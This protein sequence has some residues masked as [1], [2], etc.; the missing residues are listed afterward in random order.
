MTW[1]LINEF[2]LD[3]APAV[4]D[5][6]AESLAY[7]SLVERAADQTYLIVDELFFS[8]YASIT[9]ECRTIRVDR[10]GRLLYDS[11]HAG[12]HDGYGCQMDDGQMALLQRTRWRLL[13]LSASGAVSDVIDLT[14]VSKGMPRLV[15]WTWRKTFLIAFSRGVG[16]IEIAEIDRHGRLLW[17]LP[18]R[19]PVLGFAGSIQLL[20]NGHVLV[21]DEFH[22]VAAELDHDGSWVWQFGTRGHSA[23]AALCL[24]NPKAIRQADDGSRVIADTRNHRVIHL[25]VHGHIVH[26][27][28]ASGSWSSPSFASKAPDGHFLVCDAGN[29]RVV[30]LDPSGEV[31][32]QYGHPIAERRWLSFPRSVTI[33]DSGSYLVADTAN[34]RVV[35]VCNGAVRV[36]ALTDGTELFWP[37][38][39][40]KLS[41]GHYLIADGRN[42]RILEVSATGKVCRELRCL[43]LGGQVPLGDPH[44][45]RQ[46]D[47]GRLLVVDAA[48]NLVIET[49]WLGQVYWAAGDQDGIVLNDPHSAQ[50]LPTGDT[51]ICDTG[52]S[53]LIRVD[54]S[55]K[56]VHTLE[57]IRAASH[58][59][60]LI[61][62]RYC[63]VAGDGVLV[64]ADSDNNR[65][66]ASTLE[67]EYL[68]VLSSIPD[69][70]LPSLDQPRWIHA[71]STNELI[72]SDHRHHRILHLRR[73]NAAASGPT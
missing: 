37:R 41:S 54:D 14:T 24:S 2:G 26:I 22:H 52:N 36:C 20:P 70:R 5:H 51:L 46:L 50:R 9:A 33:T 60:R 53:R 44:D 34:N 12:I 48:S 63:E 69:S 32:W 56:I 66:L 16:R 45:V 7:P 62:P 40:R 42:S 38:C 1:T 30:E 57:T 43:R 6:P 10:S 15:T 11:H 64:I 73:T 25:D 28:P 3:Y 4:P 58:R 72:V 71:I 19:E 17:C 27:E 61:R 21:S 39:V 49:D 35:E 67:G 31:V 13:V 55:G 59:F 68:W 23:S 8:K 18:Q 65:I 47:N 29:K